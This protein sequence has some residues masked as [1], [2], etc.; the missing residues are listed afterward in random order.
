MNPAYFQIWA[1]LPVLGRQFAGWLYTTTPKAQIVLAALKSGPAG[2]AFEI[3]TQAGQPIA[4]S[5]PGGGFNIPGLDDL[6]DILGGL[7]QYPNVGAKPPCNC[8][9]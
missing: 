7:G 3:L 5:V 6:G 4:P 1:T 2:S 8:G 9:F